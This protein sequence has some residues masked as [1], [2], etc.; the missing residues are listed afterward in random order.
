VDHH[1]ILRLNDEGEFK[2][3][4]HQRFEDVNYLLE[5]LYKQEKEKLEDKGETLSEPGLDIEIDTGAILDKITEKM[6]TE[7]AEN[8]E[9]RSAATKESSPE[10]LADNLYN[11]EA[12][13]AYAMEWES[14]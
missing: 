14:V 9:D 1:F 2:I 12:A 8:L 11:R 10:N 5:E 3:I 4:S 7:A 6:L 13:V